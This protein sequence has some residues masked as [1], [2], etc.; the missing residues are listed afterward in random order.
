MFKRNRIQPLLSKLLC[1]GL[2]LGAI[3]SVL[4]KRPSEREIANDVFE[5]ERARA[6]VIDS[7]TQ[8]IML[9][10]IDSH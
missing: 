10:A 5:P 9:K 2:I 3:A 6:I 1:L 7:N 8:A 4:L